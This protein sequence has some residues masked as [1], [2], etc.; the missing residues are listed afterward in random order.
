MRTQ[1]GSST[2]AS[3]PAEPENR[4]A[5]RDPRRPRPVP[6]RRRPYTLK[7][8]S[9]QLGIPKS[10]AHGILHA[11]RRQGYLTVD[12]E[13]RATRSACS[14][15]GASPRRPSSS[16][17]SAPTGVWSSSRRRSARQRSSSGTR[18]RTASRS[19]SSRAR[20]R[21]STPYAGPALAVARN[22]RRQALPRAVR[23]RGSRDARRRRSS[24]SR[25]KTIIDVDPSSRSSPRYGGTAGRDS[26]RRSSR[27]SRA[28]PLP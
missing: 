1:S 5:A 4:S 10:T 18:A 9:E 25:P 14:S 23:R 19:I 21:S 27:T 6:R 22:R 3:R 16:C 26:A 8:V 2:S 20:A 12:P 24:G 11:M 13:T 17:A 28:S 7:G 15:S